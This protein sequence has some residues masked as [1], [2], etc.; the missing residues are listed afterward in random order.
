MNSILDR[1]NNQ[2]HQFLVHRASRGDEKSMHFNYDRGR[3]VKKGG[4]VAGYVLTLIGL[5]ACPVLIANAT[6][7]NFFL[8]FWVIPKD[9]IDATVTLSPDI[10]MFPNSRRKLYAFC[11]TWF[12]NPQKRQKMLNE[13]LEKKIWDELLKFEQHIIR[14]RKK[15]KITHT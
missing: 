10:T 1:F 3:F 5:T 11:G 6:D 12:K 8:I 7:G 4:V 15:N 14:E 13:R 9:H 2:H